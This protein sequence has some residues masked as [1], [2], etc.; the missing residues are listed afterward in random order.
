M[1]NALPP[2]PSTLYQTLISLPSSPTS[3]L[4]AMLSPNYW[5]VDRYDFRDAP[6]RARVQFLSDTQIEDD[7]RLVYALHPHGTCCCHKIMKHL[8]RMARL[9][10]QYQT[11]KNEV[12]QSMS[13][14]SVCVPPCTILTAAFLRKH[15]L[16]KT[17]AVFWTRLDMYYV[18]YS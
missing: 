14:A 17:K 4:K 6:T 8:S 9:L 13:P 7:E 10:G 16:A 1:A 3:E 2:F 5:V 18:V 12:K 11:A 15:I